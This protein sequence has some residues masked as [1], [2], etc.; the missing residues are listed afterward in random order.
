MKK[1]LGIIL[2]IVG[3][4][5]LS[6]LV[7]CGGEDRINDRNRSDEIQESDGTFEP[8]VT[9]VPTEEFTNSQAPT[10]HQESMWGELPPVPLAEYVIERE[11]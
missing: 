2:L 9:A 5:V 1:R 7:G 4:L 3:A 6:M 10:N 8:P 11:K